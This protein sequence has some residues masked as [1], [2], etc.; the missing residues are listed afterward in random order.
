MEIIAS[1]WM[2]L[3]TETDYKSDDFEL[4]ESRWHQMARLG[5][6]SGTQTWTEEPVES[7]KNSGGDEETYPFPGTDRLTT[8]SI[9]MQQ[10]LVLYDVATGLADN[11]GGDYEAPTLATPSGAILDG[12]YLIIGK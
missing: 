3:R 2:H 6:A 1:I 7:N 9:W 11:K 8:D 12:N 10:D 5:S 4:F